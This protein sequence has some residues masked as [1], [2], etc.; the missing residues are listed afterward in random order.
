MVYRPWSLDGQRI[1]TIE[2]DEPVP[3]M[4]VGFVW[5]GSRVANPAAQVF[6]SFLKRTLKHGS[7]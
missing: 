2:I 7:S 1:E 5:S 4:D 6:L 3:S